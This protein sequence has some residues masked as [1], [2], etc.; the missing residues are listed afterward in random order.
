M[1]AGEIDTASGVRVDGGGAWTRAGSVS[2]TLVPASV[3]DVPAELASVSTK[4]V[5]PVVPAAPAV[6][7]KRQRVERLRHRR[8]RAG[9]R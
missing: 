2:A 8:G 3:T 6:G 7:V 1:T 4:V 5:V 9:E